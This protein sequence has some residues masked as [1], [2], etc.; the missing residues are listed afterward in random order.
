MLPAAGRFVAAIWGPALSAAV[1][2]F[3]LRFYTAALAPGVFG[4]A[5]L[6]TTALALIDGLGPMAFAQVLAQLMKDRESRA[7][8]TALGLAL[9]LWFSLWYALLLLVG[10]ALVALWYGPAA[11]LTVTLLAMPY[12]LLETPRSS[13]QMVAMLDRR[14]GLVSAWS[15]ADAIATMALS[16]AAIRLTSAGPEAL[17][18]GAMGGRMVTTLIAAPLA[19]G[20]Y[21]DWRL[22]CEAARAALPNAIHFG[23]S[24][25]VMAPLAWIGIFADRYITGATAGLAA[26]GVLAALAG[27][28]ARPFAIASSG[29]TNLFRPDLLD[30]A[31]GR[32]T[33]HGR[34][35]LQWLGAALGIGLA[36]VIGIAVLGPWLADFLIRFPTPGIDRGALMVVI[37]LSQACVILAHAVDNRVLAVGRS[38][39]LLFSQVAAMLIGLPLIAYGA[40]HWGVIGAAWGRVSNELLKLVCA[41]TLVW[42]IGRGSKGQ[43]P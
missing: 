19:L 15:A 9:G 25:A 24:V 12:C 35:L 22:D 14:F 30:Q 11:A 21:R 37:A 42:W 1:L 16:L 26:A 38:R 43:T 3:S 32:A 13:G 5:V 27:T 41:A 29:L 40:T 7:D 39:S 23:W 36:G 6:G 17:L 34:P 28:V 20:P 33:Q 2:F 18:L 8:R 31:A 4:L 10:V